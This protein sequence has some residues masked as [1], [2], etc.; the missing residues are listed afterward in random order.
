MVSLR[1]KLN[2]KGLNELMTSA[3]VQSALDVRGEALA[4]AAGSNF[5]YVH[6]AKPHPWVARGYVQPKNDR[7]RREEAEEKRL[8]R[9]LG[10]SS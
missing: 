2:L 9:A 1:V 3:P 4:R 7:G 6:S 5:E 8:N 10:S